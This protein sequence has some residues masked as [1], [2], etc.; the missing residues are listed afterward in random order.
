MSIQKQS[1][2]RFYNNAWR[3]FMLALAI[4]LVGFF[5]SF[6]SKLTETDTLHHFHGITAMSWIVLLIIQPFLYSKNKMNIHRSLGKISFIL[7]PSLVV[8]GLLMMHL[9]L[10]REGGLNPINYILSF[11]DTVFLTQFIFFYVNAI[12]HRHNLQLHARYMAGTVIALLPPGLGRA[13][14]LIPALSNGT[15]ALDITY[16]I[17]EITSIIL[18][19]DDKK[20]GKVYPPYIIAL[21]FCIFQHIGLHFVADSPLW[22]NLMQKFASL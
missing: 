19:L 8:S 9:M 15:V 11:L 12:K 17:L 20:Q 16:I 10:S 13:I 6:I 21:L 4:T 2:V 5:N 14:L 7:V 1:A 18:I 3:W 22:Q